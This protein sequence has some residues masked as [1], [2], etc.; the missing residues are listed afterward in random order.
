MGRVIPLFREEMHLIIMVCARHRRGHN[1]INNT[2]T[3]ISI[4][5]VHF[6][7]FHWNKKQQ[8][9]YIKERNATC[10]DLTT[11][12]LGSDKGEGSFLLPVNAKDFRT[13][14]PKIYCF[15]IWTILS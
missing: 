12:G 3:C 11:L 13:R 8:N 15:N 7:L 5:L 14:Y 9:G 6:H 4:V 1:I 2:T 10:S